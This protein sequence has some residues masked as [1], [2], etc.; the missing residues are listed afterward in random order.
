MG[1][2]PDDDHQPEEW[3]FTS[4]SSTSTFTALSLYRSSS[5]DSTTA[6]N[7]TVP[8]MHL[9]VERRTSEAALVKQAAVKPLST[10]L[11]LLI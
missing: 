11:S 3:R 6:T 10:K 1:S 2:Q 4:A 5:L 7:P 9:K 8:L